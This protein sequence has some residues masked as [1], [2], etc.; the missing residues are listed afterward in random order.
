MYSTLGNLGCI[1]MCFINKNIKYNTKIFI[2]YLHF[3]FHITEFSMDVP[4]WKSV[5]NCIECTLVVY[6]KYKKSK[7]L[8]TALVDN[9]IWVK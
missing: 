2:L 9:K 6:F 1:E 4:L 5:L 3:I 8:K 7:F